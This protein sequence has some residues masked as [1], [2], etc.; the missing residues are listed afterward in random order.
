MAE[1]DAVHRA[2][3]ALADCLVPGGSHIPDIRLH[4]Q[5]GGRQ[6]L[7]V[8]APRNSSDRG[9]MGKYRDHCLPGEVEDVNLRTA[10]DSQPISLRVKSDR[11][12]RPARGKTLR[13][14]G[15]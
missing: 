6:E 1:G 4:V 3:V 5:A 14:S 8:A 9:G 10:A 2:L 12:D 13:L 15:R 7:P 11:A